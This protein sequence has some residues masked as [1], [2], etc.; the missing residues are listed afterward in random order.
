MIPLD[1]RLL[2]IILTNI[3]PEKLFAISKNSHF[4]NE[5]TSKAFLVIK[6]CI[7]QKII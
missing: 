3:H 4:Q 5:A 1:V 7:N 2:K 6:S